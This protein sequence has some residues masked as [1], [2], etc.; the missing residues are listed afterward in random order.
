MK[1]MKSNK[2]SEVQQVSRKH[3]P[4]FIRDQKNLLDGWISFN[5]IYIYI[6][7]YIS[8]YVYVNETIDLIVGTYW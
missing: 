5:I 1:T 4:D 2:I 6:Y 7:H 3:L 8:I